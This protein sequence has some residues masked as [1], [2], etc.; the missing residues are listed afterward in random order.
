MAATDD[1]KEPRRHNGSPRCRK[2]RSGRGLLA[3]VLWTSLGP[4]V[5]AVLLRRPVGIE[6]PRPAGEA[7]AV[8]CRRKMLPDPV[9]QA[10]RD[11][12]F[13]DVIG[14]GGR[15]A[16]YGLENLR[17]PRQEVPTMLKLSDDIDDFKRLY[18]KRFGPMDDQWTL[19]P[20][21]RKR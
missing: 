15:V 5:L 21:F 1:G 11:G 12:L 19:F 9:P 2:M 6:I 18:E 4:P 20:E 3:H 13:P 17:E 7:I 16:E 14:L 10:A 8:E